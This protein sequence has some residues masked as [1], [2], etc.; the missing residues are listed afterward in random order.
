MT[1]TGKITT[2]RDRVKAL[3]EKVVAAQARLI[4][5]GGTEYASARLEGES[6]GLATAI[7]VIDDVLGS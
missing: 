7:A 4:E 6:K 2:V 1:Q 5:R 3:K